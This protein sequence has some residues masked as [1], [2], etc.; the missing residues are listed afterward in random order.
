[1][2]P[3]D[4]EIRARRTRPFSLKLLPLTSVR[5][6]QQHLNEAGFKSGKEDG[7]V[8]PIT[9]AAITRFQQFCA[10]FGD[11]GD[12]SIINSGPV[13]GIFGPITRRALDHYYFFLYESDDDSPPSDDDGGA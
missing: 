4:D 1:M 8:G 13:D 10:D 5:G 3:T 11:Q 7:I 12:P 9:R 6:M 2:P